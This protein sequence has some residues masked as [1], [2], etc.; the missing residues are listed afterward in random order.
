MRVKYSGQSDPLMLLNGKIYDVISVE[1]GPNS[2][3][4]YRIIDE[5]GDDYLYLSDDF[6]IEDD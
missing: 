6:E 5:T 4:W 2:T 3:K 1:E